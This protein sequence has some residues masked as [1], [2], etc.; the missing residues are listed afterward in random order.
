M[1]G[2]TVMDVDGVT[3]LTKQLEDVNV[4]KTTNFGSSFALGI[5]CCGRRW[6]GWSG[7][8]MWMVAECRME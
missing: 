7:M 2:T 3:F 5:G 1:D 6:V 8:E 4:M